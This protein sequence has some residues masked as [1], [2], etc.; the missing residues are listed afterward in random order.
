MPKTVSDSPSLAITC[1][2]PVTSSSLPTM[3][4]TSE[5]T[6]RAADRQRPSPSASSSI[7]ATSPLARMSSP[8]LLRKIRTTNDRTN[9]ASRI[10][11]SALDSCP[12]APR[13]YRS[14]TARIGTAT[15]GLDASAKRIGAS[16]A[17]NAE[18]QGN[19]D[20][21]GADDRPQGDPR[22]AL[23]GRD[24]G[25]GEVFGIKTDDNH[26][27]QE[28]GGA[29]AHRHADRPFTSLSAKQSPGQARRRTARGKRPGSFCFPLRR[30]TAAF[31]AAEIQNR[32][33]RLK[34]PKSSASSWVSNSRVRSTWV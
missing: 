12:S 15:T 21:G 29:E 7:S 20:H 5:P 23:I 27:D 2:E 32:T 1:S 22:D 3:I 10:A 13:P 30:A 14:S 6:N 25:H 11:P 8:R 28:G 9:P 18:G 17:V 16:I 31:A 26:A 24:A 19:G 4:A 34:A 33:E